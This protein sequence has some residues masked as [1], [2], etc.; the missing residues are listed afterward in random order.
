MNIYIYTYIYIY[1]YICIY[2]YIYIYI[3]TYI[4]NHTYMRWMTIPSRS[5]KYVPPWPS[6]CVKRPVERGPEPLAELRICLL[7]H[8]LRVWGFGSESPSTTQCDSV[9]FS[10]TLD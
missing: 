7:I 9:P 2:I 1:I 8:L 6:L 5:G 4:Y 10:I 3:H